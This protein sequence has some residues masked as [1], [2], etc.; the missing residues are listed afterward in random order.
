MRSFLDDAQAQ[1]AEL[2]RGSS[3]LPE[4]DIML[5]QRWWLIPMLNALNS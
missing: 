2:I 5:R 1:Q 4:R 3:D